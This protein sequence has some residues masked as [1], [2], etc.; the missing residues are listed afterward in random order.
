MRAWVPVVVA[1]VLGLAA[2]RQGPAQEE[3]HGTVLRY[4]QPVPG[5]VVVLHQVRDDTAGPVA[6]TRTDRAGSFRFRLPPRDSGSFTVFLVTTEYQGVRYIG[7]PLHPDDRPGRYTVEVYDTAAVAGPR[8]PVRLQR[9]DVILNAHPG[10]GWEVHELLVLRNPATRTW[11]AGA[12]PV[13][14]LR[15][16]ERMSDFEVAEADFDA[17]RVRRVG[18][19]ATVLAPITPGVHQ[20]L[21]RYRWTGRDPALLEPRADTL[22]LFLRIPARPRDGW[23]TPDTVTVDGDRFFRFT[24]TPAPAVLQPPRSQA[25]RDPRW[26]AVAVA[27]AALVVGAWMSLRRHPR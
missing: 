4:G 21:L 10:G 27:T 15:L 26:P 19:Y 11:V 12:W 17:D 2:P 8:S 13:W 24:W 18:R 5:S 7:P 22:R 1:T 9:R 16:P 6:Q 20:L 14:S 3:L 25:P 23:P